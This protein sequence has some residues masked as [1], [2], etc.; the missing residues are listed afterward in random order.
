MLELF[1]HDFI[2]LFWMALYWFGFS[3]AATCS[4]GCEGDRHWC[5]G[6]EYKDSSPSCCMDPFISFYPDSS[7]NVIE[8][9]VRWLWRDGQTGLKNFTIRVNTF[10]YYLWS[11]CSYHTDTN[12]PTNATLYCRQHACTH[13]DTI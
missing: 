9:I 10:F 7:N 11:D 5:C 1:R 2:L 4:Y 12:S 13:A 6:K 3:S 8:C